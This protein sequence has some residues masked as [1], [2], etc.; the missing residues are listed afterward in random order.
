[1][2]DI[3]QGAKADGVVLHPRHAE[4]VGR[5]PVAITSF[6]NSSSRPCFGAQGG[7]D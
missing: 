1:V 2:L 3:G 5:L 4:A 6:E 7:G